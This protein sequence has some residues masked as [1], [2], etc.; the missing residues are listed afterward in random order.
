MI[1]FWSFLL[2]RD[3]FSSQCTLYLLFLIYLHAN[4]FLLWAGR[5]SLASF[6]FNPFRLIPE[7]PSG[8]QVIGEDTRWI[9]NKQMSLMVLKEDKRKEEG[10]KVKWSIDSVKNFYVYASL[11]SNTKVAFPYQMISNQ[12]ALMI[13]S[14]FPLQ[15][16]SPPPSPPLNIFLF[17]AVWFWNPTHFS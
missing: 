14:D 16:S 13:S 9:H 15:S 7:N 4:P 10:K 1:K 17:I 12:L 2:D 8:T 3:W 6:F 5:V 11:E